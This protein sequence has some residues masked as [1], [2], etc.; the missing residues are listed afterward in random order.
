[1]V[2]KF[3]LFMF[4]FCMKSFLE[5]LIEVYLYYCCFKYIILEIDFFYVYSIIFYSIKFKRFSFLG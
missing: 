3:L 1:M 5:V 4:F 2:D